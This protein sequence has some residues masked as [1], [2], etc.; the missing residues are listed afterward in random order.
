[1]TKRR[2]PDPKEFSQFLRLKPFEPNGKKR[3]LDKA[4]DLWD[5]RRIA[6]RRTP[7]VAFDY[8]DGAA[9]SEISLR[10]AR[11]AY[12]D[13]VFHPSVLRDIAEI[14]TSTEV[15]GASA[16]M[17]L[18]ICPTGFVRMMNHEGEVAAGQAAR[19]AGVPF[20]LSC[21]GTTSIDTL[22]QSTPGGRNW[23]QLYL[24]KE[25]DRSL[26]LIEQAQQA[27]V[28]T[29]I[30]TVDTAVAGARLRDVRNG[31]TI[32][33]RLTGKTFMNGAVRPWWWFNFLTTEPLRFAALDSWQG[34]VGELANQ[35]FDPTVSFD[36]V[37]WL[38]EQWKGNL[39]V[40]GIQNVDDAKRVRDHGA[41]GVWLSNHGG[42]QLDRAPV[43]LHLLPEVRAQL[44]DDYTIL[45]DTGIMNGADIVAAVANGADMAMI[46]RAYLYGLMAAGKEGVAKVLELLRGEY[47]R[48]LQLL[49]V[50]STADLTPDHVE[51]L[52]R[53][54][55][56]ARPHAAAGQLST[57]HSGRKTRHS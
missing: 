42:R 25:R 38:R 6:K 3:R 55:P 46:G 35:M 5:I 49:G 28:D 17:P 40:K 33:P 50:N 27:G 52:Q 32:P 22:A 43:P 21:M 36:D 51:L 16:A 2:F 47:T 8:T 14:D 10:R 56:L 12:R 13:I 11:Q 23:F 54:T 7:K 39:V 41:D 48:T 15:L 18:G 20:S 1:M 19:D 44:G 53:L 4:A 31:M 24:W 26:K 9:E 37:D 34:T 30:V 45:I 29:L 57:A